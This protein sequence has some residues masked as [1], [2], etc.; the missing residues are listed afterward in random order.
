VLSFCA[1]GVSWGRTFLRRL[2]SLMST[3]RLQTS[4]IHLDQD[5]RED[6]DWWIRFAPEFNGTSL[7]ISP[8]AQELERL[9]LICH[10]DASGNCCAGVWGDK[11]FCHDFTEEEKLKLPSIGQRELYAIICFCQ[12]F[13]K[14]LEGK[15]ILV[16]CDNESSVVAINKKRSKVA[17]MNSLIRELFYVAGLSSFQVQ[18][19][20]IPGVNNCLADALSRPLLRSTA[21]TIRPSL[22]R[23]PM[24]ARLPSLDW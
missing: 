20:H 8:D 3:G 1:Y 16:Y 24:P 12:T 4:K 2:I 21:W 9:G 14:A 5:A 17:S 10:T 23:S 7:L 18:A 15:T 6:L 13:G 11:W 22:N 19:K